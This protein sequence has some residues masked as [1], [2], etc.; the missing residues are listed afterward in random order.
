MF[1]QVNRFQIVAMSATINGL[2]LLKKWLKST[3]IYQSEYRPV[4]LSEYIL[5]PD[6]GNLMLQPPRGLHHPN[7]G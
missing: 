6:S 5:R 7:G 2:H 4:P 3:E 1:N